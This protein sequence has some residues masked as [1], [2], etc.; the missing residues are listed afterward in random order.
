MNKF[1]Q[2]SKKKKIVVWGWWQG[3]NLGDMW[4]LECIKKKFPGIIPI[5]TNDEDFSKYDFLIIGGGGLLNGPKL[6]APFNEKLPIKYGA[7]GLGGEFEIKEKEELRKLINLSVFFGVRDSRNEVTYAVEGNNKLE[8]SGDCTF[9]FPL[10][11]MTPNRKIRNIKLI[12]R[13]PYGL[14]K[15]DHSRHHQEDGEM[16]NKLFGDYIGEIPFNNNA[17]L[18][19]LYLN[20][21]KE[22]GIPIYDNYQT[23][24]GLDTFKISD[25]Y[26]RFRSVD[27]VVSMRLHGVIAAIQLGIPCIG[28]D[29]YPKVRTV[30]SECGIEK[31]CIKLNEFDKLG[32]LIQDI[33]LN[34]VNIRK[35]MEDYVNTQ[36]AKVNLFGNKAISK[37][38]YLMK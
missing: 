25:I 35:K 18:L 6:R 22:H 34:W 15:W 2:I 12:W 38:E 8:Q 21:L 16:L 14:L 11:K 29:I 28:L 31:Y 4:I 19:K 23:K 24:P 26:D 32:K 20:I 1:G 10:R 5:T 36:H 33:K 30:M 9:L 37:I 17:E 27:L 7:F 3:R 13:D